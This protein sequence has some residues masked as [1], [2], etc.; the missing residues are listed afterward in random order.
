MLL[1]ACAFARV[2]LGRQAIR[3]AGWL[4]GW[5]GGLVVRFACR[6]GG[7]PGGEGFGRVGSTGFGLVG[8][9]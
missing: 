3:Q 5:I 9:S 1:V 4:A 6:A 2:W 8:L 7:G